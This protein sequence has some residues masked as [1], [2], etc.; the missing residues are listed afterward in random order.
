MSRKISASVQRVRDA[1]LAAGIASEVQELSTSTRTAH[2]AADAV[3]CT[4]GQIVKSLIVKGAASGKLYLVLTSGANRLCTRKVAALAGEEI[5]MADARSVRDYTGFAIGGV[6]PLGHL[7][8]M[9]SFI[10]NTLLGL[11]AV[12]AAAG[13]PN[14]LFRLTPPELERITGGTAAEIAEDCDA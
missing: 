5:G 14:A 7:N 8:P 4:V 11:G 1:L 3:G 13:S 9:T 12:W 2:E 6:P 10:D